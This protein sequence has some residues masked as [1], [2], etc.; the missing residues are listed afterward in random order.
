M[1]RIK[2]IIRAF[3]FSSANLIVYKL[4]LKNQTVKHFRNHTS[5]NKQYW[6][7]LFVSGRTVVY[8]NRYKR[9]QFPPK[10]DFGGPN[11]RLQASHDASHVDWPSMTL[12]TV[13][14][15]RQNGV[16]LR[17]MTTTALLLSYD[18]LLIL[19]YWF[20]KNTHD[21]IDLLISWA[22]WLIAK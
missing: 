13:W 4:F 6:S 19:T 5:S 17:R 7:C 22:K 14:L 10:V 12:L 2:T 16:R 9:P 8:R 3:G 15:A 18:G 20:S 21:Y 1:L 11:Y